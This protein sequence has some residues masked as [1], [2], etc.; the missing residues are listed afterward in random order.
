MPDAAV[1]VV[2]VGQAFHWFD[3]ERAVP[4]IA[5]VLRP[6]GLLLLVDNV[7]PPDR[8]TA[9]YINALEKQR[10]PSHHW[11]YPR[12][13]LERTLAEAGLT[14]EL[15]EDSHKDLDFDDWA[16]RMGCDAARKEKLRRLFLDDPEG[17]RTYFN[18]RVDGDRL[19]FSL[20]EALLVARVIS[21]SRETP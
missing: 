20:A 4:E 21:R 7:V 10:D 6:G 8:S 15:A 2:T 17:P 12:V 1:D 19:T 14:L 13:R 18:P 9:G 3:H 16:D 11:C 5:R